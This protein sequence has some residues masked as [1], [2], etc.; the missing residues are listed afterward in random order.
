MDVTY[1]IKSLDDL[2]EHFEQLAAS[3][4]EHP[5]RTNRDRIAYAARVATLELVVDTIRKTK[6]DTGK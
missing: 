1:H 2:A 3:A 5:M 6:M 4:Q